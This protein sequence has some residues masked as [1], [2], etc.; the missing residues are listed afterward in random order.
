MGKEAQYKQLE[1][2]VVSN[3]TSAI[4]LYK[5]YNFIKYGEN[6]KAFLNRENKYQSIDSMYFEWE[7]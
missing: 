1:L 4:S 7:V 2:Q 5:K 6:H 3:N